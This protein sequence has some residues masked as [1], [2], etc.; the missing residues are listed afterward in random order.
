MWRLYRNMAAAR[1]VLEMFYGPIPNELG[2]SKDQGSY[3]T[4]EKV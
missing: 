2:E 3:Q 1:D 4:Q